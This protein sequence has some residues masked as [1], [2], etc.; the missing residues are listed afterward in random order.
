MSEAER[1]D[2][3]IVGS[4]FG[5]SVS[6]LRLVEKG[7]RVL[8]LEQGRRLGQDDF[9]TTNWN[10]KR[11]MWIPRLGFRG[12]FRMTFF[13][14]LTALSGVGVGGGSLVYANTLPTPKEPFYGA[15]S[16]AHLAP[17]KDELAPHYDT[18]LRMLG[19][20]ENALPDE[21]ERTLERVARGRGQ[22]DGYHLTRVGVYF[23][24]PD[25]ETPD[26]FFGGEGPPR[27]GCQG[28]GG[29]MTGCRHGAKNSLDMNYL[30]LAEKKGLTLQAD[31][32]VTWVKPQEGGGYTITARQGA[33]IFRRRKITYQAEHVILAGGVLGTV[34]LLLKLRRSAQGLPRLSPRLGEMVRTNSECLIGVTS[35]RRDLD[36]SKGVAIGAILETDDK[37][38]LEL[39]RYAE[40]S[41][42]F[43]TIG[44][45]HVP[46][47]NV[48]GRMARV[49][50]ALVRHPLL[51]LRA[52]TVPDWAKYTTILLYMRALEGTLKL[53]LGRKLSTGFARG[54]ISAKGDGERATAH[55]PEAT[56]LA[57][58]VAKEVRGVPMS[59]LQEALLGVPTTAHV[60]GGCCMGESE[61]EGVID[62][63]HR[64]FGYEGLYVIDGSAISANPGV[65]PS[66]TITALGERAM[67]LI[68][69][70]SSAVGP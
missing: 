60:L 12:I 3:V 4:G 44:L 13:R 2:Y 39:V 20:V 31:T 64:V 50:M 19:A 1:W 21:A 48:L 7:Y 59:I 23:G 6:A 61:E 66:L 30:Y 63:S 58:Q 28:C 41:G 35:S 55:M 36:L 17:W 42:F 47:R 32:E 68:P 29:S 45:P 16:W 56:E 40:G 52:F 38:H 25:N 67:K 69:E 37:S 5:G 14:H 15:S 49:A 62:S 26:P 46:G 10:L 33:S 8:L 53:K 34:P 9:P 43:R 70:A 51:Y 18:A 65:N 57:W 11:W 24:D 54:L 27:T 22:A